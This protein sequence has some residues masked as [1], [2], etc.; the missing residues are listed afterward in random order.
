MKFLRLLKRRKILLFLSIMGPGLITACADNDAGGITTYSLVGAHFGYNM[1]WLLFLTTFSLAIFQEMCARMG[2]VT[3]K[4]LSD[5]IRE[6]FGIRLTFF[7]MFI[8]FIANVAT[9]ISNFA[10]IAASMEIFGVQKFL[11]VPIFAIFIWCIV[12]LGSYRIVEKI[13]FFLSSF[14]IFYII[15]GFLSHPDWDLVT[16]RLLIP[17]FDFETDFILMAVAVIGTTITPW[18][19]FYIQASV[20]EKGIIARHYKYEKMDVL[21]GAFVTNFV[22]FFIIIACA[23]TLYKHGVRIESAKDAALALAPLSGNFAE[24]LFA[25]GLFGASILTASV[26]PLSTSYSICEALGFESGISKKFSEA[27]L[28]FSLYTFLIFGGAGFV[29]IPNLSLIKVMLLAQTFNGFLLPI[30]LVLILILVNRPWVMGKQVNS[31]VY[32]FIAWMTTIGVISLCIMLL[33]SGFV[34]Y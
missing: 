14:L 23:G 25:A 10:G 2:A 26:V 30:I 4:G 13:F 34:K 8:L 16:K 32:N 3:G 22:A 6:E 33:V 20:V 31:R 18:M 5:L 11:S 1:L 29:L 7:S 9:T 27:K 19:Q 24:F 15:S 12:I 28:F 17:Q 21:F